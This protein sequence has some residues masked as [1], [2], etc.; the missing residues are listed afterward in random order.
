[1]CSIDID[2]TAVR[3]S[4]YY[5]IFCF[6]S[7]FPLTKFK[8]RTSNSEPKFTCKSSRAEGYEQ[9]DSS[10]PTQL[11]V[12]CPPGY[13]YFLPESGHLK[14][15]SS[16]PLL[17]LCLAQRNQRKS[18]HPQKRISFHLEKGNSKERSGIEKCATK[19]EENT[20]NDIERRG[21]EFQFDN[22]QNRSSFQIT[23]AESQ[24]S[25]DEKTQDL[26]SHF[27][28]KNGDTKENIDGSDGGVKRKN[29]GKEERIRKV[30]EKANEMIKNGDAK[31]NMSDSDGGVKRKSNGKGE[32]IR[33]ILEMIQN[34]DA[35]ENMSDSDGGVKRKKSGKDGEGII[36]VLERANEMIIQEKIKERFSKKHE[37]LEGR[38]MKKQEKLTERFQ[39]QQEKA[40]K[41]KSVSK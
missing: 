35:K 21:I 9:K 14:N 12:S 37:K 39:K 20:K 32:R 27:K 24:E 30:L 16:G 22:P 25:S 18:N 6:I 40:E 13:N 3:P 15:D 41:R 11:K 36:K 26:K 29:G 5:I 1:M 33:K 2:V 28:N 10:P 23:F 34:E 31:E 19:K 7:E 17:E 8:L 4:S 38:F